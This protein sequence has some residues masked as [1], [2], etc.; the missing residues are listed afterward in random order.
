[1][2]RWTSR[3]R[4]AGSLAA[5]A[6]LVVAAI[7]AAD[8]G[9]DAPSASSTSTTTSTTSL[10]TTT[11]TTTTATSTTTVVTTTTSTAPR[12]P[13]STTSTT[14]APAIAVRRGPDVP[15]A[16]LTFDA[17]SDPGWTAAILDIL[18]TN[19]VHASFGVTGRF[20]ESNP[21]LVH[22]MSLEGHVV[23]N[24]SYDHPSFTG[25]STKQLPLTRAERLDQLARADAAI[26]AATG[27]TST[28][29][30]RP[31]YGDE[32]ASV[33]ADV[34]GAGYGYEV[35]WTVDSLGWRGAGVDEITRR[36]LDGAGNGVIYLF[37][38]GR[39][40][41]DHAALQAIIDG[42]RASGLELVTIS[43]LLGR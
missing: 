18:A 6:V 37:H 35:M 11:T 40:S 15:R 27:V 1:M 32:D 29:W 4:I 25:R 31:P 36:C 8:R 34:G 22:R 17:G 13:T 43:E 16:A 5:G 19:H 38:V 12:D 3:A 14:S 10:A 42:L 9:G 21:A 2:R 28:P 23:M 41:A 20:A 26:G 30:F 7:L 33:R 24:H 39:D